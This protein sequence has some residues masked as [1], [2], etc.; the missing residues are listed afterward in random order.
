M[1]AP[2]RLTWI[3]ASAALAPFACSETTLPPVL[4]S[5]PSIDATSPPSEPDVTSVPDATSPSAPN[6]TTL[7]IEGVARMPLLEDPTAYM[8]D[9]GERRVELPRRMTSVTLARGTAAGVDVRFR[10][11]GVLRDGE[12]VAAIRESEAVLT[13][14]ETGDRV[15]YAGLV[16]HVALRFRVWQGHVEEQYVLDAAPNG[17]SGA[18][19][20]D[21]VEEFV[22]RAF[23]G[24]LV[25]RADGE[26]HTP[27]LNLHAQSDIELVDADTGEVRLRIPAPVMW[28]DTP[29]QRRL[30]I[31]HTLAIDAGG[32]GHYLLHVPAAYLDDPAR[33]F[34]V[35]IDPTMGFV[36]GQVECSGTWADCE[37]GGPCKA[38]NDGNSCTLDTCVAGLCVRTP[39]TD[40]APDVDHCLRDDG[41]PIGVCR[42]DGTCDTS[43]PASSGTCPSSWNPCL[44][45]GTGSDGACHDAPVADGTACWTVGTCVSGTCSFAHAAENT[46]CGV[47]SDCN[48]RF[49]DYCATYACEQVPV[50]GGATQGR[51]V[52]EAQKAQGDVCAW[53][54]CEPAVGDPG[55]ME[56]LA[57]T[58]PCDKAWCGVLV[59]PAT[60]LSN[61]CVP[62]KIATDDPNTPELECPRRW[63]WDGNACDY[64]GLSDEPCNGGAG[65]CTLRGDTVTVTLGGAT[66]EVA[67]SVCLEPCNTSN[68]ADPRWLATRDYNYGKAVDPTISSDC[69][70]SACVDFE[71]GAPVGD[72]Q[73]GVC[74]EPA[75][76]GGGA[77]C[78]GGMGRCTASMHCEDPCATV[79]CAAGEVCRNTWDAGTDAV[80]ASCVTCPEGTY[81]ADCHACTTVAHCVGVVRCTG[82]GDS[83]C[84]TC[85]TGYFG[86]QCAACGEVAHCVGT[87]SCDASGSRCATCETGYFGDHCHQCQTIEHCAGGVSCTN[88][89]ESVC[90]A[91]DLGYFGDRCEAC[92][93][94]P[95]CQGAVSCEDANGSTCTVECDAGYYGPHCNACTAIPHCAADVTCTSA[96]DSVC[97]ACQ[98]GYFGNHCDACDPVPHC[99]GTTRCDANGSTC[100]TCETGYFG[101]KC[102]QCQTID[103]CVGPVTCTNAGD[104]SCPTCETGY[105]GS[106]CELCSSV[107]NCIGTVTCTNSADSACS[108]CESGTIQPLCTP[109]TPGYE[110]SADGTTCVVV[111]R[112]PYWPQ[113]AE[114]IVSSLG[115]TTVH[116][117]W[118][119]AADETGVALYR[120]SVDDDDVLEVAS[121]TLDADLGGLEPGADV[122]VDI[123]AVDVTGNVSTLL[124]AAFTMVPPAPA[125]LASSLETTTSTPFVD[126]TS[127]LYEG[128]DPPQ[129]G[130]APGTIR[131][132]QAAV[133]CGTVLDTDGEPLAAASVSVLDHPDYGATSTRVDGGYDLAVNGGQPI[134]LVIEHEG[135]LPVQR[136]LATPWQD[137]TIADPIVMTALPPTNSDVTFA[138]DAPSQMVTGPTSSDADGQRTASLYIPEGTTALMALPGGVSE[139]LPAATR[140]ELVEYTVGQRGPAAMPGALPASSGYTY[141][142]EL[143]LDAARE[144][145]AERVEFSRPV[146]LYVDNYLGFPI[147]GAVPAGAYERAIGAWQA[148]D[149]GRVVQ[150]LATVDGLADLDID[151]SGSPANAEAFGVLGI[152]DAER[153]HL[154]AHFAVGTQLWRVPIRHF[155]PWDCNWPFTWPDDATTPGSAVVG[156]SGGP[157]PDG[158]GDNNSLQC[159]SIIEVESR[160]LG[161]ELPL[162]GTPYRL[163]YRSGRARGR[164]DTKSLDLTLAGDTVPPSLKRID[165]VIDVAG[166]RHTASFPPH[167]SQTYTFVWDGVDAYGR[168]VMSPANAQISLGYVY[169]AVYAEPAPTGN[170][171]AQFG[172]PTQIVGNRFTNEITLWERSR[173]Q[174]GAPTFTGRDF[175]SWTLNVRHHYDPVDRVLYRGDGER[176]GSSAAELVATVFAGTG[177]LGSAGDGGPAT[178]AQFDHP[179]DIAVGP[180]GSV[181][182]GGYGKSVQVDGATHYRDAVRR[183]AT[184]GKICSVDTGV[185]RVSGLAM[186]PRGELYV[187]DSLAHTITR[188]DVQRILTCSVCDESTSFELKCGSC[189]ACVDADLIT[190]IAGGGAEAPADGVRAVD[191]DIVPQ[192]L[193][194]D[195]EGN[196]Y[197]FLFDED[198]IFKVDT[199]GL[200]STVVGRGVTW[201]LGQNGDGGPARD[202]RLWGGSGSLGNVRLQL[203]PTGDLYTLET[204]GRRVRRVT[205][206]G[207]IDSIAGTRTGDPSYVADGLSALL[208]Y[209]PGASDIAVD[210]TG[211]V[212]ITQTSGY[213]V[214]RI[215]PS[216]IITTIGGTGS[217]GPGGKNSIVGPA[218]ASS[219]QPSAVGVS[220]DGVVYVVS[221]GQVIRIAPRF[222]HFSGDDIAI[223]SDDGVDL[224]RFDRS[225]RHLET[226]DTMTGAVRYAFEYDVDG[227]LTSVTDGDGQVTQISRD[228]DAITITSPFGQAT[229]LALDE[230]GDLAS[231]VDPAGRNT[232]LTYAPGGLLASITRPDGTA[233][234]FSYDSEGR[235]EQDTAADG[236]QKTLSTSTD[237]DDTTVVTTA[238]GRETHVTYTPLA[239]GDIARREVDPAGNMIS[240]TE[241]HDGVTTVQHPDGSVETTSLAADPR[242]GMTAPYVA[243]SVTE[244]PSGLTRTLTRS[245]TATEDATNPVAAGSWASSLTV[246]G[247]TWTTT[248][249]GATRT[250]TRTTPLGR[251]TH[252]TVDS[253]SRPL[254]VDDPARGRTTY[255][256]DAQG[257]LATLTRGDGAQIWS[258]AYDDAGWLASS[259]NPIG[260]TTSYTHDAV[261]NPLTQ[262]RPDGSVTAFTWD[263]RDRL[264]SLAPPGRP[265]HAF[266]YTSAGLMSSYAPPELDG[267]AD[268]ETTSYTLDRDLDVVAQADGRSIARRYDDAGRLVGLDIAAGSYTYAYDPTTGQL[269]SVTAPDGGVLS[270]AYDGPLL[271]EQ[272]WSG[273]VSGTVRY[274][275]DASFRLASVQVNNEDPIAYVRDDDGAITSAGPMTLTYDAVTG[276]LTGTSVGV[277]TTDVAYD[278]LGQVAVESA[279]VSGAVIFRRSYTRDALGRITKVVELAPSG[280]STTTYG[281]DAAGR[282]AAVTNADRTTIYTYDA[283]GNR[284][285]EMRPDG[286]TTGTYDDRDRLLAY[287]DATLTYAATGAI[288][289][290]TDARGTTYYGYDEL[291]N[292]RSAILPDGNEL[293]YVI[294]GMQ[295][296]CGRKVNGVLAEA[297]LYWNQLEPAAQL[298]PD[299]SVKLRFVYAT[300]SNAPDLIVADDA[301]FRIVRDQIG[302]PRLIINV[303]TGFTTE[304]INYDYFGNVATISNGSHQPIRFGAGIFDSMTGLTRFGARDFNPRFARWIQP[305]PIRFRGGGANLYVAFFNDPLDV[306]DA[307][308]T[309]PPT[310]ALPTPIGPSAGVHTTSSSGDVG[311]ITG[312]VIA[313]E[314]GSTFTNPSLPMGNGISGTVNWDSFGGGA[315]CK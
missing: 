237:D 277:V 15:D 21:I 239:T 143:S 236:H 7:P 273:A 82:P 289:T 212:Y 288:T 112:P 203:G 10:T 33:R 238:L 43:P 175:G 24:R 241:G 281:Y 140:L 283:N 199:N 78:G 1:R 76:V 28:D 234:T 2:L 292:L 91:C 275:Y 207:I 172:V 272:T 173:H 25:V 12:A 73:A 49:A 229:H 188:V 72:G 204:G 59:D 280:D 138:S 219:M 303:L 224:Y 69:Y 266:A 56:C 105:F 235:L 64:N 294:D 159:G 74:S 80:E 65:V 55:A 48:Y 311:H 160:V 47:P 251:T 110:P 100:L 14:A 50:A 130:V 167:P 299:G 270:Y 77:A 148:S 210:S 309:S 54:T 230:G 253:Q 296:R 304:V 9:D 88:A 92:D 111:D 308:G 213:R 246:D 23:A 62:G 218:T 216:G 146:Y 163:A 19:Y 231:Y 195:S 184:D 191:A 267:Q 120:I 263:E 196:L 255:G 307:M 298:A 34:P 249:D 106:G 313:P 42:L 41:A 192:A 67:W 155:T 157:P 287:G 103:H 102:Q 133:I 11:V 53:G 202:A 315:G 222:P 197:V 31:E 171:F 150:V 166:R 269:A 282:L 250:Y 286:T 258:L 257:R 245:L 168:R 94:V 169:Q 206:N 185:R 132:E 17:P 97:S 252:T 164:V 151:G 104:S 38:C 66:D 125:L 90:A 285:S 256:Y 149:N 198:K 260:Q 162:I 108:E 274:T 221:Q 36:G 174:F 243:S 71:S 261:G 228:G 26:T 297:L 183:V 75:A 98:N 99:A 147:G 293:T 83:T 63:H 16:P 259:T 271:T 145:G 154:A 58:P 314:I 4:S 295:R 305:D 57:P 114:L 142:L 301:I 248:Y 244:L 240:T 215:S 312:T 179:S 264:T 302:S 124:S 101:P 176:R 214:R 247:R 18:R 45:S 95:H 39:R 84:E 27:P 158:G 279:S 310:Q 291:G 51:C 152:S 177:E 37:E 116:L 113:D 126:G 144:A 115:S 227:L 205:A 200:L 265:A 85:E 211:N 226:Y 217:R 193:D 262:T 3:L 276:R 170:G 278:D 60:G 35:V 189:D 156:G 223:A 153:A 5:S 70:T 165:L 96:S 220:P 117:A 268:A 20:V 254:V 30:A 89:T 136:T 290:L 306:T 182:I 121:D 8:F 233:S 194:V 139:P 122:D 107:P 61:S 186:G 284:L 242:F 300:I 161:E 6:G 79:T 29:R 68:C 52:R 86:N 190:T 109:C 44:A 46:P 225:G 187:S 131:P 93:Q 209:L 40:I 208:D 127:F 141:A 135:F 128:D 180:D 123:V 181:Y 129:R 119:A 201:Y 178:D 118:P 32:D 137:F 81:G 134:I 232:T 87:V 13:R 22:L